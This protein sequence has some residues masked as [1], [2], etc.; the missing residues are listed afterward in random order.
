MANVTQSVTVCSELQALLAVP[1][2]VV[3]DVKASKSAAVV[4]GDALAPF[5]AALEG[6][7]NLS[8]EVTAANGAAVDMTVASFGVQMKQLL[9]PGSV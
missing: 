3:A 5:I 8:A 6:L 4:A 9:F 2:Q 1:L 7:Q